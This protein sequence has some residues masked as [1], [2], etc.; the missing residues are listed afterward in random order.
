[1]LGIFLFSRILW[2]RCASSHRGRRYLGF[3]DKNSDVI[4]LHIVLVSPRLFFN[5]LAR[6]NLGVCLI[7]LIC[8]SEFTALGLMG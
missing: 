1:V 6:V 5:P 7:P 8:R 2:L 4:L 3:G